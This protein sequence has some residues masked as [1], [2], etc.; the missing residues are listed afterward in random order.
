M[1]RNQKGFTLIEIIIVIIIVGLL[2]AGAIVKYIS[3]TKAAERSSV[4]SVIGSLKSSLMIYSVNQI[5]NM[6][7]IT[8]HN[9]FDDL[10]NQPSNYAGA[11]GDVNLSNCQPGEWAYQIGDGSNGNWPVIIYR[12][13]STLTQAFNWSNTQWIVLVI[14]EVKNASGTT[15]G[16]S[17]ADYPP[18][19]LW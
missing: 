7:P 8:A 18:A 2:G 16:L 10:S 6:Q 4:E 12:P 3:M 5:V 15:I 13:E 17:L 11:F 14:S 1:K 19:H 9:P